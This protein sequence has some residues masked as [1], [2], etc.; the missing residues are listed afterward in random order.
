MC[1]GVPLPGLFV[2]RRPGERV[3]TAHLPLPLP[4]FLYTDKGLCFA[5]LTG[6]Q[7]AEQRG[8]AVEVLAAA[9]EEPTLKC[10]LRYI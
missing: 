2:G 6:Q 4:C 3:R 10:T 5:E 7:C 1:Q 8:W 9:I